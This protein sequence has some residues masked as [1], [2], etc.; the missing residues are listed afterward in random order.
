[1]NRIL[2]PRSRLKLIPV[3]L[4]CQLL[5]CKGAPPPPPLPLTPSPE[6][7]TADASIDAAVDA[8]ARIMPQRVF[9]SVRDR[10]KQS[11]PKV[12][13]RAALDSADRC[14]EKVLAGRLFNRQKD[15][16]SE[17]LA[18]EAVESTC[19]LYPYARLRLA[20]ARHLAGNYE[21]ALGALAD[22]PMS[23]ALDSFA[24]FQRA[25][26]LHALHQTD[27]AREVLEALGT[28][29][30]GRSDDLHELR[31]G[32]YG[33]PA[34]P[35]GDA[36][37]ALEACQAILLT[38]PSSA[39]ARRVE[40]AC[41][42][43]ETR[44]GKDPRLSADALADRA[45]AFLGEGE[46]KRA[47]FDA[48]AVLRSK[49]A[50]AAALCKAATVRATA[51]PKAQKKD[52]ANA[53]GE[54]IA[55]CAGQEGEPQALFNGG[56]ASASA[57]TPDE[58]IERYATLERKYASHRLADDARFKS[59]L[60]A[61]DKGDEATFRE[62]MRALP[63]DYPDGDMKGEALF[64]VALSALV[65]GE[66]ELAAEVLDLHV[67]TVRD[68]LHWSTGGRARYF[69]ARVYELDGKTELAAA[70]YEALIKDVPPM[71]YSAL[72]YSRLAAIS[73]ARAASALR[74]GR[75]RENG[76]ARELYIPPAGI[77]RAIALLEVEDLELAKQELVLLGMAGKETSQA[78]L[79]DTAQLYDHTEQWSLAVGLY[80]S[81]FQEHAAHHPEGVYRSM[82]E[83][84]YPA[85]FA[86]ELSAVGDKDVP[87]GFSW[88]IMREESSFTPEIK[89]PVGAVGLM[90][91]M[92][93]TARI[94][95]Q[96]TGLAFDEAAL[97]TPDVSIA[98][99]TK[100]LHS[101]RNKYGHA[102]LA[103]AGYNAGPGAV[104]RWQRSLPAEFDL[105]VES[106]PY[107]E[108]R[109]YVKRVLGSFYVYATLYDTAS[110]PEVQSF[111]AWKRP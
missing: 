11:D 30:K 13:A 106:I 103:A 82:W 98:L 25:L 5:A 53:W 24:Q 9:S 80:R 61:R 66:R 17:A 55:R 105:F 74:E 94:T 62:R 21:G 100:L 77:E 101:L 38:H 71:F 99:G 15:T 96:G 63:T 84:G 110:L 44:L 87:R 36:E 86:R 48:D 12:V 14:K 32:V 57:G 54:A 60:L 88:A 26:S 93:D 108:T 109:G 46:S 51:V 81:A 19:V 90:Q 4:A 23:G 91:L 35:P 58:A 37:R 52:A 111:T 41:S 107:E 43:I 42:Q 39:G 28:G 6:A 75:A 89:S 8:S 78:A 95:A 49:N 27:K 45:K 83:A 64:R 102:A 3:M 29:Y 67:R 65:L 1:V 56:K 59:A 50:P 16:A 7:A 10:V 22:V 70:G 72:A 47:L 2:H 31:I 73:T 34:A 69:R 85:A 76:A 20:E 92:P 68:E 40:A 33:A 18:Y 97:K 104:D 79:F